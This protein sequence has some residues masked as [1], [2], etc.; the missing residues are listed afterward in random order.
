[1]SSRIFLDIFSSQFG[2][3]YPQVRTYCEEE[4]NILFVDNYKRE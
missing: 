2:L 4:I 3:I 1:M